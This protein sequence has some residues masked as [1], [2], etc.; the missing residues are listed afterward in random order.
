MDKISNWIDWFDQHKEVLVWSTVFSV[1][2]WIVCLLLLPFAAARIPRDF[3]K[4]GYKSPFR[5]EHPV[6]GTLVWAFRNLLG[7]F[8]MVTGLAMIPLPGPGTP[9]LVMGL[10]L[11]TLPTR[12]HLARMALR[13]RPVLATFNWLRKQRGAEPFQLSDLARR[14]GRR[15]LGSLIRKIHP[16]AG[17]SGSST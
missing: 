2:C 17:D 15:G 8:I 16:E 10:L 7:F 5:M 3:F 12:R 14:S 6:L 11:T 1:A 4:P 13:R 9:V